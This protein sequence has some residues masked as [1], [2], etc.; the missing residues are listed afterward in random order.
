M[1]ETD[2]TRVLFCFSYLVTDDIST[3]LIFEVYF[4]DVNSGLSFD[5]KQFWILCSFLHFDE[6]TKVH[7]ILAVE[8]NLLCFHADLVNFCG[9]QTPENSFAAGFSPIKGF[10]M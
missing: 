6:E 9:Q 1:I 8:I 3:L 10:K 7:S 5:E 2:Y 4:K